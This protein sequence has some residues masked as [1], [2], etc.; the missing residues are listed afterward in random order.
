[1]NWNIEVS[2]AFKAS[3]K[4]FKKKYPNEADAVWKNLMRLHQ[5][6]TDESVKAEQ[7]VTLGFVHR[8][9][10]GAIAV[11]QKGSDSKTKLKQ[12]RLYMYLHITDTAIHLLKVGDK[13]TQSA[14]NN[15]CKKEIKKILK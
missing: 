12:T 11:D 7:A 4:K 14:D 13:N 1:M 6:L 10:G 8:E 5:L 9:S 2:D 15:Y 3:F